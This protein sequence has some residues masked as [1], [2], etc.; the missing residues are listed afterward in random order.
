MMTRARA[1]AWVCVCV[2]VFATMPPQL[3]ELRASAP[4]AEAAREQTGAVSGPDSTRI[5]KRGREAVRCGMQ[6]PCVP[7]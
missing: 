5:K 3:R 4:L 7:G 6:C 2:C 1:R